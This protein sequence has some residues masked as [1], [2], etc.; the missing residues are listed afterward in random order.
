MVRLL[1]VL[2]RLIFGQ[3][4]PRRLR[5]RMGHSPTGTNTGRAG[6]T[7]RERRQRLGDGRAGADPSSTYATKREWRIIV[8][9]R[10]T[11]SDAVAPCPN[12][13][14]VLGR[15]VFGLNVFGIHVSSYQV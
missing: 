7:T 11:G 8:R 9:H 13:L 12:T 15:G 10:R 5:K 14:L 6:P 2:G 3:R 1:V 4:C